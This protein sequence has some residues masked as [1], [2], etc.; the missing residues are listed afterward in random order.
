MKKLGKQILLSATL[1]PAVRKP[2]PPLQPTASANS[3][4]YPLSESET[5]SASDSGSAP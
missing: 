5:D 4:L 2:G 1:L 3:P